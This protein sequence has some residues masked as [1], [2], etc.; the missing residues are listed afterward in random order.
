VL[1]VVDLEPYHRFGL[2]IIPVHEGL[3][4]IEKRFPDVAGRM[5]RLKH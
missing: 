4:G 3:D 1:D 5:T 2:T